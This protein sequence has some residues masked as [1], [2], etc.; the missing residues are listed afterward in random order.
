MFALARKGTD[1]VATTNNSVANTD[2][3]DFILFSVRVNC[4]RLLRV[5]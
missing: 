2:V 4:M 3:Q 1:A 5:V